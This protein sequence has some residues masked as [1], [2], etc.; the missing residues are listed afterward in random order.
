MIITWPQRLVDNFLIDILTK[1]RT[2]LL[3]S[4][5]FSRWLTSFQIEPS[6]ASISDQRVGWKRWISLC[7]FQSFFRSLLPRPTQCA[8]R[9][10]IS[11]RPGQEVRIQGDWLLTSFWPWKSQSIMLSQPSASIWETP[12]RISLT[13]LDGGAQILQSWNVVKS[14]AL[15]ATGGQYHSHYVIVGNTFKPPEIGK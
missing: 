11:E 13:L 9:R 14:L 2:L 8:P 10:L 5:I 15:R 6:P 7:S 1:R 12:L 4:W 3:F